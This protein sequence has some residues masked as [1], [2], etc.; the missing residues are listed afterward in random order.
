MLNM[1]HLWMETRMNIQQTIQQMAKLET[2][3]NHSGF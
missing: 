3:V 2:A 1:N